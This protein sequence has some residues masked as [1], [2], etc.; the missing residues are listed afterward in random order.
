MNA[1]TVF[2]DRQLQKKPED[3]EEYFI[4]EEMFRNLKY[5]DVSGRCYCKVKRALD[6]VIS[7]TGL[8]FL[9]IP[10]L[11]ISLLIYMDD[12]G[13]VLFSQK[14]VGLHGETFTMYK[15]RTMKMNAP[16]Y[17]STHEL[18]DPKRYVT[19]IG[20]TLRKYSL[21]EIPQLINVLKG[22]MSLVGPRP[23]I[24]NERQIHEYRMRFG[25]YNIRPGITGLAQINGRDM[26]K[27][28]EKI[29]WDVK[30][31]EN[32]GF[33]QDLRIFFATIPKVS[34]GKDVT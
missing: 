34:S 18:R 30:Y 19:P 5:V 29:Q 26:V 23:L 22:D 12:P 33:L 27:P 10:F 13:K 24:W 8:I 4:A 21:D 9:L 16:K 1:T 3:Q 25:V 7:L 15:F 2:H 6:V 31:L 14:R 32:F 17:V 11:A 20:N 28:G